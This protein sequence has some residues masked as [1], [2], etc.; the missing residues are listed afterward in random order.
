MDRKPRILIIDDDPL[1]QRII[2]LSL[3]G[4]NYDLLEAAS[5]SIGLERAVS[6]QPDLIILDV[7]MPGMDGFEVCHWLRNDPRTTHIIIIFVTA[8]GEVREKVHGLKLGGDD[9]ITKP[10]DPRELRAR[11]QVQLLRGPRMAWSQPSSDDSLQLL[12]VFL[13]HAKSDKLAVRRLY[14]RL[15]DDR[16]NP[17]LDDERLLPGQEWDSVIQ[18]AVR[19][20]D[21]FLAC[22]SKN[23]ITKEGYVQKEIKLALDVALEKPDGTI[24]IIPVRLEE[25]S[26]PQ[27]LQRFQY[28]DYFENNGYERLFRALKQRAERYKL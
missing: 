3:D 2:A 18:N 14:D 28:V 4:S 25:C 22:L 10:F 27:R 7:L 15:R 16:I 1:M 17:W 21:V 11:V 19:T 26:V 20:S 6:D 24:Y 9:Y 8:L 23:S 5:G 12:E 13:C